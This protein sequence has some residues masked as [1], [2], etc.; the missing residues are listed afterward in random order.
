MLYDL[1]T[2]PDELIDL[3]ENPDHAPQIA[4]L[5]ELLAGWSR[6]QSQ[7]VATSRQMLANMRGSGPGKGIFQFLADGSELPA[8]FT[9]KQRGKAKA[10]Y[11]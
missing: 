9:E 6:R 2:D 11:T 10:D 4:R 1:E 8:E 7:R 5:Y 3:A